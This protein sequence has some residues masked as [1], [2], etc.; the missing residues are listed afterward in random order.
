M[1]KD[2]RQRISQCV[3]CM[4]QQHTGTTA[5][6]CV[7]ECGHTFHSKCIQVWLSDHQTCP[8]CRAVLGPCNHG[9]VASHGPDV[10]HA[11]IDALKENVRQ[12]EAETVYLGDR[13][14]AFQM[15]STDR[16]QHVPVSVHNVGQMSLILNNV[17]VDLLGNEEVDT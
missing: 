3:I 2:K 1:S 8:S 14:M 4:E 7:F 17:L 10:V 16:F 12:L 6:S 15:D 13:V 11:V 5:E 9:D